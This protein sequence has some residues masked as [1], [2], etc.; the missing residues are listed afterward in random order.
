MKKYYGEETEKAL[1]N[2]PFSMHRAQKSL[3]YA[4]VLV[5]KAAAAANVE[6]GNFSKEI[7]DAIID[8]CDEIA[9]GKFD[10]QFVT[11]AL[12]GGAGTSIN[13]NVNEVLAA[14]A[15]ELLSEKGVSTPVHPLDHVNRSQS[16]NDVNP[17]GLKIACIEGVKQVQKSISSL[18]VAFESKAQ[19]LKDI[20]KL[21]RTHLQD[22]VPTTFGAEFA[23]YT[24]IIKRDQKRITDVT[25]Y[26]YEV[27]LGGTAIGNQINASEKYIEAVYQVLPKV[28]DIPLV[29]AAN[30]MP[31]T[32]STGD[33]AALSGTLVVFL[34]D[35]SKIANDIRLMASGPVGAFGE[36]SIPSLQKGSSIMPGKV[37]PVI[38]ES[39]NQLYFLVSGYNLTIVKATEAAQFELNVM[40]PILADSLLISL[41][42]THEV[43]QNFADQCVVGIKVQKE[44]SLAHLEKSMAYATLL[45]PILG[46]DVVDRAVKDALSQQKTL[47]EVIVG[48]GL[49]SESDFDTH[50]KV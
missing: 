36:I 8:A 21:G 31:G 40:F 45:T 13:M 39:V 16:T 17:T 27:N 29:P 1:Q 11:P 48:S 2:F 41:Q 18:V 5:K 22:A 43:V 3:I 47:R 24:A 12:Q 35:L 19:E 44:R 15:T 7:G 10:D 42:L 46:Y 4:I 37:N 28:T 49:L 20:P 50:T 6:A 26:L 38:P 23:S 14:R 9:Q 25:P 32:S 33:F 34:A 30:F